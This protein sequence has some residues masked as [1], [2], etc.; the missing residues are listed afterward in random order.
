MPGLNY[1]EGELLLTINE[2]KNRIVH[3]FGGVHST[4]ARNK[5]K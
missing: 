1:L 2:H 3:S 5:L 4:K